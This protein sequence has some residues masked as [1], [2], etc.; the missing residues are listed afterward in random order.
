M[1]ESTNKSENK[2][3]SGQKILTDIIDKRDK[4]EQALQRIDGGIQSL[5]GEMDA[6]IQSLKESLAKMDEPPAE[7]S[8]TPPESETPS[9]P[10]E[11]AAEQKEADK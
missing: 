7:E 4:L 3:E 5:K 11:P 9:S 1:T 8:K 2:Y 10:S 6:A